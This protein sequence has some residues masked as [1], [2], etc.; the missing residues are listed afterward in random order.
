MV[1]GTTAI[2][3]GNDGD[4]LPQLQDP[5]RRSVCIIF[6]PH[7]FVLISLCYSQSSQWQLKANSVRYCVFKIEIEE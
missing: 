3:K 6:D 4:D 1:M 5:Y 2:Y 7:Q